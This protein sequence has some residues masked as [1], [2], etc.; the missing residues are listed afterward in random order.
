MKVILEV[1]NITRKFGGLV[2]L[3]NVSFKIMENEI[4]ALIGPNG[5]GKTTLFNL[6]TGI[7]KATEGDLIFNGENISKLPIYKI[8]RM[9]IARSFQ[10]TRL[11]FNLSVED[12]I[13]IGFEV[14]GGSV[15]EKDI[16]NLLSLGNLEFKKKRNTEQLTHAEQR[17]LM[18]L[19]ALCC[20]PK[21][22]LLDEPITGMN[23]EEI[24]QT[25]KMI[26]NLRK[27]GVTILLIE[28]NL[29]FVTKVSD[30]VLVLNFGE[31][32][33]E[34]SHEEV[35]KNKKVIDAYIGGDVNGKN[36]YA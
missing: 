9:G 29:K 7:N 14:M 13:R 10:Q 12:N 22:M 34:G 36:S 2:A 17:Q 5:A 18:I 20:R 26:D 28:H 30:R 15:K 23:A 6:I 27:E 1:K 21:L 19:L 25:L 16:Y 35:V 8:A 24:A 32:I 3:K 11:F 33:A 31:I 4:L